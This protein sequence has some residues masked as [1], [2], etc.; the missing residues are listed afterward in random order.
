MNL[1]EIQHRYL[2]LGIGDLPRAAIDRANVQAGYL[3]PGTTEKGMRSTPEN[4]IQNLMRRMW[5]DPALR[6]SILDIREMDRIDPRVKK[7]HG[8]MARTAIKGGLVL[9]TNSANKRLIRMWRDFERRLN[10]NRREKLESDARGLAMEGNLVLQWV[11]GADNRVAAGIRMPAE[12]IIPQVEP[13]GV[14]SDVSRAYA[15]YDLMTGKIRETFALWQLTV[16]RLTPDNFDDWG[17]MGRPYLDAA[18]GIWTKLAMTEEDLVI[19]RK[20][21]AQ[22]RKVH[23]LKNV[24]DEFYETYREKIETDIYDQTAD[25]VIRGEGSVSAIQ[26]DAN[27]D[28]IADVSHL[29]D[30]F[31]SGS[32]APKGLF[33]YAGDLSRDILEDLKRDFYD[34]IDSMQDVHAYAYEMGFRLDLLL[35]GVNPDD[36]EFRVAFRERRTDTPNQRADLALKY[37]ALGMSTETVIETAGVDT[38]L[39][40]ERLESERKKRSPYPAGATGGQPARAPR[41]AVTPG[42]ARKGESATTISTRS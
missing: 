27:L 40:A 30:T 17:S 8:R 14:F 32:P 15:Q 2:K 38:A 19:R 22:Q 9:R 3:L 16:A 42:N 7:I 28:Q 37:Q 35:N 34:E 36:F 41:V 10:L 33:G 18:R 5:I 29:L 13:S 39:E 26:G 4:Q 12:T 6:A 11:L 25:Y 21:R 31:F 24:S 20:T 1:R 23:Q